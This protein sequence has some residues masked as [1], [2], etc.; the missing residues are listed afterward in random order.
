M[1][2]AVVAAA[3]MGAVRLAPN[4]IA[5]TLTYTSNYYPDRSWFVGHTW[6]LSVE[7]QF[8]LLWPAVLIL[9]GTRRA[10]V[11]AALVVLAAPVIRLVEWEFFRAATGSGIGARFETVADSIAIGCLLAGARPWLHKTAWYPRLL[12]SPFF[13]V[14]PLLAVLGN[15]T[16]DHPIVSFAAGMTLSNVCVALALDWA[17]TFHDGRIGRVLNAAPLVF[18]GWLSYSLYLWQQPFLNRASTSMVASFPLNIILTVVLALVSYYV[19]ER[20]SLR[21][22]KTVER[23]SGRPTPV[24]AAKLQT[25]LPSGR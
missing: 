7:E 10:F 6:S 9:A 1:L 14:V 11:I 12:A 16:H 18:V 25:E 4:D 5:H 20:P 17:V 23:R 2:A 24:P 22:R 13:A 19:V 3:A 8:Y 21:L 15:L